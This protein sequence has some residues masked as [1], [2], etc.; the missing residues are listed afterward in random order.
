M[1]A[2]SIYIFFQKWS[3]LHGRCGIGW[4]EREINFQIFIKRVMVIFVLKCP[5][6]SMNFHDN[7]KNKNRKIYF[8]FASAYCA[9]FM[10]VES[11][12]GVG[13]FLVGTEPNL[14]Y[15]APLYP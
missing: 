4:I 6:F 7:S 5:P 15:S 14:F 10:K 13:I 3:N 11:K 1:H 9:S 2:T 12:L 8:L